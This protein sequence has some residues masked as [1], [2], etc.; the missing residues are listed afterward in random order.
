MKIAWKMKILTEEIDFVGDKKE[1]TFMTWSCN[2]LKSQMIKM[3]SSTEEIV[4]NRN[5]KESKFLTCGGNT[6]WGFIVHC[7]YFQLHLDWDLI[8]DHDS[9]PGEIQGCGY[10]RADI[11]MLVMVS[12]FFPSQFASGGGTSVIAAPKECLY[13]NCFAFTL[14]V[15]FFSSLLYP[16]S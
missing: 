11:P 3:I 5:E 9:V 12:V 8:I 6:L 4:L 1:S 16:F 10:R 7:L 14:Q 13:L 2:T 15:H